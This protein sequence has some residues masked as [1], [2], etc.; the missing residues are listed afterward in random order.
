MFS[1]VPCTPGPGFDD[2]IEEVYN[3]GITTGCATSPLR[4]CPDSPNTR[5]QMVLFLVRT[6][7]LGW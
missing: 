2:E 3:L 6:F 1:D 7:G 4:Y 5:G